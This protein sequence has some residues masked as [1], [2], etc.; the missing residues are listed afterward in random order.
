MPLAPA[1]RAPRLSS[2][3]SHSEVPKSFSRRESDIDPRSPKAFKSKPASALTSWELVAIKESAEDVPPART[4]VAPA[5][6]GVLKE[7]AEVILALGVASQGSI[8]VA[9]TNER[10]PEG[11]GEVVLTGESALEVEVKVAPVGKGASKEGAKSKSVS[12]V[13]RPKKA[14]ASGVATLK[15]ATGKRVPPTEVSTA[16]P[17]SKKARASQQ[18]ALALPPLEKEKMPVGLLSSTLDNEVLNTDEITLQSPASIVVELLQERMFGGVTK[19][20]NPRLLALTG[21]LACSTREQV[22]FRSRTR[23]ELRDTVRKML[24][25]VSPVFSF[26]AFKLFLLF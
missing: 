25:M 19:A 22:A 23:E 1:S 8:E 2:R 3:D 9:P 6:E 20:S 14:A 4:K 16:A 26:P 13:P 10:A 21:L 18:S 15:G 7:N 11:G 17:A 12:A 24:L 5:S